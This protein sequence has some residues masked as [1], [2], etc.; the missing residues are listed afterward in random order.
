[1]GNQKVW[2]VT[3]ASKGFGLEIAKAVLK[4]GDKVIATCRSNPEKL[5]AE[6][7]NDNAL[8]VAMD[9]TNEDQVKQGVEDGIAKFGNLDVVVNNAGYGIIAA[10]EEVSNEETK[11]QYDTN[12]FGL[13]NVV[14][15]VLP[16][17]RKQRAGHI[18]NF[19]SLFGYGAIPVYAL[20]G[21]T[22][23]AVEGLSK[24]LAVELEA[25][26]IKVTALAP[27]LFRTKFLEGGSYVT[28]G[29]PI[30]DYDNTAVG[31]MKN[32]PA[33]LHGNQAGDP[34]KLA[35]VVVGLAKEKNPP[36]HLPVGKDSLDAYRKNVEKTSK[37]IEQWADKFP[38]TEVS[39]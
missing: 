21:S 14:R 31:Q 32:S 39:E 4:S 20:Y 3:G 37:E 18:I 6:L 30:P 10:I 24:G 26:G 12:V 33:Q 17:M 2:L 8:A 27:G 13:L 9:V 28:A 23:F 35:E 5:S 22:K 34:A 1:M 15:A 25:F 19:S 16:Y 11:R 7:N 36:L 29:K 38:P